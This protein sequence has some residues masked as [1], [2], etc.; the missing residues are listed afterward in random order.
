MAVK[1]K[2]KLVGKDG[3]K[4]P[5]LKNGQDYSRE[6]TTQQWPAARIARA[7]LDTVLMLLS[8]K[9]VRETLGYHP[10]L[11]CAVREVRALMCVLGE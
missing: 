9:P 5:H 7:N 2:R 8:S 6:A 4:H 11:E 10:T 1:L 3:G